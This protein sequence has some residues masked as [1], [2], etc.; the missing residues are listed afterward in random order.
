MTSISMNV[1]IDDDLNSKLS[2]IALRD[3]KPVDHLINK[4]IERMIADD[5][6][7]F[8]K[9]EAG[10]ADFEAESVTV[11]EDVMLMG[12]DIIEKARIRQ[13]AK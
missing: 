7:V 9:I 2:A 1:R 5:E 10:L 12:R 4:A 8:M 11:H 13:T 6:Y 3:A